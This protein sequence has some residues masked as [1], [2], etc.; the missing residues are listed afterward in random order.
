MGGAGESR[1]G[2]I[3]GKDLNVSAGVLTEAVEGG[4][5]LGHVLDAANLR[6]GRQQATDD[7]VVVVVLVVVLA[8]GWQDDALKNG[9]KSRL[10]LGMGLDR[11]R[12]R[13]GGDEEDPV[14]GERR[15]GGAVEADPGA[16]HQEATHRFYAVHRAQHTEHHRAVAASFLRH[17]L[18]LISRFSTRLIELEILRENSIRSP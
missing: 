12:G 17:H 1:K 18:H 5:G 4:G 11:G 16:S 6:S 14:G 2:T 7:L 3:L 9:E 10:G 8:R 15:C 13:G